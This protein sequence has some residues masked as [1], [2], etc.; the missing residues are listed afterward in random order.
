MSD[1]GGNDEQAADPIFTPLVANT[2]IDHPGKISQAARVS[3]FDEIDPWKLG[4]L[5]AI[6]FLCGMLIGFVIGASLVL[7]LVK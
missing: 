7:L 6:W 3:D 5:C 2:P 4:A 1:E